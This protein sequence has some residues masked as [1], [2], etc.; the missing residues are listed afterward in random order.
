MDL[1]RGDVLSLNK[2]WQRIG[3]RS[4]RQ[5]IIAACPEYPGQ[6]NVLLMDIELNPDGTLMR[7]TPTRWDD[8]LDLPVRDPSE[9]VQTKNG[10]I[11]LPRVMIASGYAKMPLKTPLLSPSAIFDRD[12]GKCQYTGRYLEPG[13]GNID[14]VIPK[15]R[16]GKNTWE[17]MV[18]SDKDLNFRKGNKLNSEAGLVLMRLP[19]APRAIPVSALIRNPRHP[20]HVPFFDEKA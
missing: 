11:R 10:A 18:W 3:W 12:G 1:D 15:D 16:G 7:A 17:N 4:H 19:K 9:A 8:W 6:Y 5:A 14:H 13:E 20:H 2:N